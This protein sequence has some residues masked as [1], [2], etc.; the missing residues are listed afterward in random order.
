MKIFFL[1]FFLVVSVFYFDSCSTAPK[2]AQ[3]PEDEIYVV[4]DSSEFADLS[5]LLDSTY[6]K[7]IYTPQPEKLFT[8][9]RIS[10]NQLDKYRFKKNI[11]IA[12]PLN[13]QSQTSRYIHSLVD[14]TVLQKIK[15]GQDFVIRKENLW[16]DNQLVIILTAPTTNELESAV[17]KN[18][19]MLV[20]AF[21]KVSDDRLKACLYNSNFENES[22][23]GS[24]LKKY[25]W[26]IFIPADFKL[27]MDVSQNNFVWL[28][29]L[30]GSEMEC[31]MFVHWIDNASP[32]YLNEDSVKAIRNRVI[33]KFYRIMNDSSHVLIAPDDYTSNEI[34]FKGRFTVLTQGLWDL[35]SKIIGG[36]FINYSFLD[37]KNNR[38]YMLDAFINAPKYYKRNLIQQMDVLLQS[39]MIEREIDKG[40]KEDLLNAA[41]ETNPE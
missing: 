11:L 19:D 32:V 9:I 13:S 14:S 16:A 26:V 8:V 25:G 29:R 39:F 24:L 6:E 18:K 27:A 33:G 20:E 30:K 40:K 31:S 35:N 12:A 41:K 38:F 7:L 21:Q 36:P 15:T 28:R 17:I 3:G 34:N 4:A 1:S 10:P 23:E 2:P 37:D 5:P 22:L